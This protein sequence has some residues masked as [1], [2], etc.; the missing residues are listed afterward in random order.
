MTQNIGEGHFID[1]T[2][3]DEASDDASVTKDNQRNN[4]SGQDDEERLDDEDDDYDHDKFIEQMLGD[5]SEGRD[6]RKDKY[7]G[8]RVDDIEK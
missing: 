7:T 2:E 6:P 4:G 8:Q 3:E 1:D 5:Y